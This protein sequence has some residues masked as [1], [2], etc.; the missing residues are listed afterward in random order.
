VTA[1]WKGPIF[2]LAGAGAG[3]LTGRTV[4]AI[5]KRQIKNEPAA[6]EPEATPEI[7]SKIQLTGATERL[8]PTGEIELQ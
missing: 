5:R 1:W 8:P 4:E 7:D 3:F 6:E 2:N